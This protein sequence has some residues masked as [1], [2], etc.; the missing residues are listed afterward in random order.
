MPYHM[1]K[2]N[3]FCCPKCNPENND[4]GVFLFHVEGDGRVFY[5]CGK[6]V[7]EFE[8]DGDALKLTKSVE[9]DMTPVE[10]I[11]EDV[12]QLQS[13]NSETET[14]QINQEPVD[15]TS[16]STVAM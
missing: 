9:L 6:C 4:K 12:S 16:V 13:E 8:L 11:I 15:D 3:K 14:G 10:E 5:F 7:S 1:L 2:S